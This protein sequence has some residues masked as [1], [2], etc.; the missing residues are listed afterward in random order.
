MS[1]QKDGS[2]RRERGGPGSGD[3][4]GAIVAVSLRLFRSFV[5]LFVCSVFDVFAKRFLCTVSF[6]EC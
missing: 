6:D 3:L 4:I 2:E 1:K 5:R